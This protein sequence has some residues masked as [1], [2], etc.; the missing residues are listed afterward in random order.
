M[1]KDL[2]RRERAGMGFSRGRA[3][4]VSNKRLTK[5]FRRGICA[6]RA[7][8]RGFCATRTFR[9]E[10]CATRACRRGICATT[11]QGL[12]DGSGQSP[13]EELVLRRPFREDSV[14]Q[15]V[16]ERQFCATGAPSGLLRA[17]LCY[18]LLKAILCSERPFKG[19]PVLRAAAVGPTPGFAA[20][21]ADRH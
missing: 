12:Q 13:E 10:F 14:L 1:T 18:E 16:I 5:P 8:R 17:I 19:Q 20:N 9:R 4:A 6:T 2:R 3:W 11:T 21:R 15:A 7:C